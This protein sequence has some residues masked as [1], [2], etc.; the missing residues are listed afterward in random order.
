[1]SKK[2]NSC[3]TMEICRYQR[4]ETPGGNTDEVEECGGGAP[5]PAETVANKSFRRTR[6]QPER[7]G[8]TEF[9]EIER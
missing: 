5:D 3:N 4:E 6:T 7:T 2:S 9:C 8:R 1:M